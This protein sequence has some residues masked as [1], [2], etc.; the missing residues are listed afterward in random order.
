MRIMY[1][2]HRGF[3]TPGDHYATIDRQ[4]V[5]ELYSRGFEAISWSNTIRRRMYLLVV[6]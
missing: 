1:I 3:T 5:Y 6:L 2:E 4:S